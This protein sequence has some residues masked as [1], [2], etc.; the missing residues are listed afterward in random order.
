MSGVTYFD[1]F[2]A[3]YIAQ[4]YEREQKVLRAIQVCCGIYRC[5]EH[6]KA[7]QDLRDRHLPLL[8]QIIKKYQWPGTDL[9]G[10]DGIKKLWTLVQH[11]DHDVEFQERCLGHLQ[12]AVRNHDAPPE[13][14]AYLNDR[15]LKNRGVSQIYGTQLRIL[16]NELVAYPIL[17]EAHLDQ[18]R[19]EIGLEPFD[20]YLDSMHKLICGS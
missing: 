10:K 7:I 3:H 17:D 20:Q 11:C 9:I 2:L 13:Y 18:R 19:K 4:M 8:Q 15:T 16:D 5:E 6:V 14:F 12:A 1:P